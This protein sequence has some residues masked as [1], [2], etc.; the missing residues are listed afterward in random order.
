MARDDGFLADYFAKV[1]SIEDTHASYWRE[2]QKAYSQSNRYYHN[3][4]HLSAMLHGLD[5]YPDE[6]HNWPTLAL[7]IFYHDII[8][9][10][11]RKDNEKRSAELAK[12]RL[13]TTS[14]TP[15]E[16]QTVH[17]YIL[18]TQHHLNPTQDGDLSLL[19]DLDLA[20]LAAPRKQYVIYTEQIRKEYWMYPWPLYRKGRRK[21]LQH[22][23]ERKNIFLTKHFSPLETKARENL[24]WE[25]GET[26]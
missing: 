13:Q 26:S 18:A 5:E 24:D 23:L 14:L 15:A 10:P 25:I 19:L 21:A 7:A 17:D 3:L 16:V 9:N 8:Y 22:F 12:T 1:F 11:L 20:I 2:I 6:I 4:D